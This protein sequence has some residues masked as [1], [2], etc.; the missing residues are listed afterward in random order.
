MRVAAWPL[1]LLAFVPLSVHA[2]EPAP[3]V[4]VAASDIDAKIDA[5]LAAPAEERAARVRDL[6]AAGEAAVSRLLER[7]G[8]ASPGVPAPGEPAQPTRGVRFKVRF[9]TAPESLAREWIGG[10]P[11]AGR[12]AIGQPGR[13]VV[14]RILDAAE[15][16]SDVQLVRGAEVTLFDGQRGTLQ[17]LNRL[18]Y[19]QDYAVE[20]A[21]DAF[22]ADPIVGVAV[23]GTLLDLRPTIDASGTKVV[24]DV[25]V[26]SCAVPQPIKIDDVAIVGGKQTVQIQRPEAHTAR[27]THTV[28]VPA[29]GAILFAPP[30]PVSANERLP[31]LLLIE[32]T[33]VETPP[34]DVRI[35]PEVEVIEPKGP[36]DAPPPLP[37]P[38]TET[39]PTLR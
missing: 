20:V 27:V 16:G 21:Q 17:V 28:T 6:A 33:V 34:T 36:A 30:R 29:G 9:L 23:E 14:D 18:S 22:I 1:G 4:A 5:A 10:E 3:T 2:D 25:D 35:A 38:G 32:A 12:L 13:E 24:L 19:I 7:L 15:A 31:N 39:G 8:A 37:A 26:S 11:V